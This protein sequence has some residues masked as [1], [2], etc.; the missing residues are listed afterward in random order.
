MTHHEANVTSAHEVEIRRV[1]RGIAG[2]QTESLSVATLSPLEAVSL[3]AELLLAS[4][5]AEEMHTAWEG[6]RER[7]A[8]GEDR[9]SQGGVCAPRRESAMKPLP[10]TIVDASGLPCAPCKKCGHRGFW[11]NGNGPWLCEKC[12]IVNYLAVPRSHIWVPQ[13]R[14]SQM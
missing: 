7:K 12:T 10:P 1:E 5:K 2:G 13:N 14:A 4:R 11:Q 6:G 9:R 8:P 3:A